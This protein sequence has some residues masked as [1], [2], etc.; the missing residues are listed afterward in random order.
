MIDVRSPSEFLRGHIPGAQSYPLFTDQERAIVGTLYKQNS[1][2]EALEAGLKLVADKLPNLIDSLSALPTPLQIYCARGGMRSHAVGH[3]LTSLKLPCNVIKGGYKQYRSSVLQTFQ[4]PYKLTIVAGLTGSGKTAYLQKLAEAQEQVLDLE[5]IA[6]HRGSIFGALEDPQPTQQQFE[7]E[8]AEK[9]NQLSPT[10][11]I[12]V[13]DEARTIGA[14]TIP[15]SLFL[16]MQEAPYIELTCSKE[17]R[18][19]NLLD[20]YTHIDAEEIIHCTK[21]LRKRLGSQRVEQI[22][23]AVERREFREAVFH[24][25][26]HYDKSYEKALSKK[27]PKKLLKNFF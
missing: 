7:N 20:Q 25:L 6:C 3:L 2:S 18:I 21:L 22:I 23:A 1:P 26:H 8:I 15:E 12:F 9:L 24:I 14:C 19:E 13:E 10:R 11:P 16:Q 5:G 17:R 4:K 27:N